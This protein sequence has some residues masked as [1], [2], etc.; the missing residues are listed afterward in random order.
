MKSAASTDEKSKNWWVRSIASTPWNTSPRTTPM[1]RVRRTTRS[2][3]I[4][5]STAAVPTITLHCSHAA[6]S[7]C[8]LES[9]TE[10]VASPK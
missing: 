6:P 7:S 2:T 4:D 1:C 3:G 8:R 5:S 10:S 9:P